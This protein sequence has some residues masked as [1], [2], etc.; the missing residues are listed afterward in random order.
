LATLC[1][2]SADFQMNLRLSLDLYDLYADRKTAIQHIQARDCGGQLGFVEVNY[3][4]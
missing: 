4:S 2:T 3:R 1:V